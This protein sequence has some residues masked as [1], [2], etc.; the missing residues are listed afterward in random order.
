MALRSRND[1]EGATARGATSR[2]KAWHWDSPQCALGS[3]MVLPGAQRVGRAARSGLGWGQDQNGSCLMGGV[4][5][6]GITLS[7]IETS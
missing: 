4:E 5:S 6:L 7:V 1:R 2:A 3:E